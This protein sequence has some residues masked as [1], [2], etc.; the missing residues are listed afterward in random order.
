MN[1]SFAPPALDSDMYFPL[2]LVA[3]ATLLL[4]SAGVVALVLWRASAATRHLVWTLGLSGLLVLP[5]LSLV[6]PGWAVPLLPV[7][8]ER[9]V[10]AAHWEDPVI[11]GP[12]ALPE[13]EPAAALATMPD[14]LPVQVPHT[15]WELPSLSWTTGLLAVWMLGVLLVLSRLA[16]GW[17]GVRR[18]ARRAKLVNTEEWTGLLRDLS[19]ILDV[20]VPVRLL[21]S[22]R[23]TMPM[24][25][26]T[27]KPVVLLPVDADAWPA[28]HRRVVLLH[29]LAHVARRDCFT[30]GFAGLACALYWFHPGVWYAARRLRVEREQACDDRVLAAGT[31]AAEYAGHLLEVARRFR[32]VGIASAAA[33]AMARPSQLEGRLLAVLDPARSRWEPGRRARVLAGVAALGL[34]APLAAMRAVAGPAERAPVVATPSAQPADPQQRIERRFAVRPGQTLRLDLRTGGD[35]RV[36]GWDRD[37]VFVRA[38]LG[39]RDW[40]D[41]RVDF[42]QGAG[43]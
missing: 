41:T 28:E 40:Q 36:I 3:K 39:G 43:G 16:L 35:V 25:W 10:L 12:P 13:P 4:A 20:N 9:P 1:P 6:V 14:P 15:G 19:W 33:V 8:A 29:E 21:R 7:V 37:E 18:L 27:R 31:R 38:G 42:A 11:P 24:T 23:A 17:W 2:V 34:V 22:E 32:P 30:Q 26:G 5:L